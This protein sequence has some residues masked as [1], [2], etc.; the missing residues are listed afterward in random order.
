M[1]MFDDRERAEET[2]F[3][4]D[5]ELDFKVSVRAHRLLAL[6][7]ADHM[8]LRAEAAEAYA[9]QVVDAS[10]T[11]MGTDV[12]ARVA[13]DM[14]RAMSPPPTLPQIRTQW[15]HFKEIARDETIQGMR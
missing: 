11:P 5:Q 10:F 15:M 14:S 4:R 13:A 3:Q 7:A 2:K 8:G 9:R 12:P 1:T 6:W